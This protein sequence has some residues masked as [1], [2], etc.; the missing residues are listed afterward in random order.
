MQNL[1]S[2]IIPLHLKWHKRKPTSFVLKDKIKFLY[3]KKQKLN[4]DL[5]NAHLKAAQKLGNMWHTIMILL[6]LLTDF[7]YNTT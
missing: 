6:C 7:Y 4:R 3:K 5:Y 2:H 1:K